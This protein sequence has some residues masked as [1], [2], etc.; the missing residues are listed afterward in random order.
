M[1]GRIERVGVKALRT[2]PVREGSGG[3]QNRFG[4]GDKE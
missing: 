4:K 1:S 3:P 2:V